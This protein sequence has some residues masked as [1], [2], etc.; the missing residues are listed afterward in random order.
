MFVLSLLRSSTVFILIISQHCLAIPSLAIPPIILAAENSWPPYSDEY[1]NGL[2]KNIIKA[3]YNAVNVNVEFISVPYAR[4]LKMTEQGQVDGAFNVTKQ[5]S[6]FE[7]F[8]FGH[9]PILQATA[10]FYYHN[11]SPLNFTSVNEIPKG[12]SIGVIIGYEY[13]DN[14]EIYKSRF[15]EVRVASQSQLIGMLRNKR[16]DM[17]IMFDEVAK[18]KLKEMGLQLNDIKKGAIN[19]KSNIYVAFSKLKNTN[20]A[21]ILLDEGLIKL[22]NN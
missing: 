13:G 3:A 2:S 5:K 9:V 7:I 19:H 15:E 6:T 20:K 18:C 11:E 14:Y 21:M 8:N 4:A 10:S 22:K 1:G 12:T 17:A 16:I